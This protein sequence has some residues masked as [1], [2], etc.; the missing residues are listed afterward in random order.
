MNISDLKSSAFAMPLTS[1]AFPRGP[2][3]FIQRD[4]HR[5]ETE[6]LLKR[7]RPRSHDREDEADDKG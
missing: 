6:R 3:H 1:P 5:L 4:L 7:L 2:Y